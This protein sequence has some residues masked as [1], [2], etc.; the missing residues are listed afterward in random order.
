MVPLWVDLPFL[1][2]LLGP[3]GLRSWQQ[4]MPVGAWEH[5]EWLLTPVDIPKC[6]ETE[7]LD[8]ILGSRRKQLCFCKVKKQNKGGSPLCSWCSEIWRWPGWIGCRSDKDWC[9]QSPNSSLHGGSEPSAAQCHT[10]KQA[11]WQD[12]LTHTHTHTHKWNLGMKSKPFSLHLNWG[13]SWPG[14]RT[15]W[16]EQPLESCPHRQSAQHRS[17]PVKTR[18]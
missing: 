18:Q 5:H 14:H 11:Y 13:L 2:G 6:L 9:R 3:R 10:Q 4:H 15:A 1:L 16:T 12:P 17:T 8:L 7:H